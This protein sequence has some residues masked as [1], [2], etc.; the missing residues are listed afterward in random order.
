MKRPSLLTTG[1]V[2]TVIV[3][4]CC[5]TPVLVVLLATLG[6]SAWLGYLDYVLLP[7]LA[8]LIGVTAYALYRRA[9]NPRTGHS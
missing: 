3:A 4:L 2:R 1:I 5:F 6:L 8:L 9:R 7:A